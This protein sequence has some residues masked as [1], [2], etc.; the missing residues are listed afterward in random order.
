MG[1]GGGLLRMVTLSISEWQT[2]DF[3]YIKMNHGDNI[4]IY[5]FKTYMYHTDKTI[6]IEQSDIE[7]NSV[8]NVPPLIYIN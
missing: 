8:N 1:G 2:F 7:A 5:I 4:Y 6:H 3:L